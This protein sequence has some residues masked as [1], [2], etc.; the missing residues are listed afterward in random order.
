MSLFSIGLSGLSAAQNA[1]S[2]TSNNISNVYTDGYSRQ[3]TL[4]G[5]NS[6]GVG[7]GAGVSVD[8]IQRQY[9]SYI[10]SQLNQVNSRQSA[11]E[12]YQ[13]QINQIDDL[14]ADSD[15]GLTTLMQGFFSSVEDLTGAPADAAAREGLLGSSNSMAAQFRAYDGYLSD[16][17]E[18]IN[19]QI[20]DV[21]TQVNNLSDQISNL[22]KQV[23][24]ARARSGE[25]PNAL[26]DQRDKLVSDLGELV[27]V[28]VQVQD[29]STYQVS[30]S[31]GMPLV[32]GNQ[33][34]DLVAVKSSDDPS[35]TTIAYQDGA[36]SRSPLKESV[37]QGGEL[38]GLMSFR[39]ETLDSAQNQLGQLAVTLAGSFNKQHE[40]GLDLNGDPGEAFFDI[41]SPTVISRSTNTGSGSMSAEYGDVSELTADDYRLT[42]QADGSY[43]VENLGSGEISTISP[44]GDGNLSVAGVTLTP[45][46]SP[47]EGDVFM[48]QPTRHAAAG[49]DVALSDTSEIAAAAA[50]GGGSGD[51]R[52]A[53]ALLDLQN[54]KLVGGSATFSGG[55]ASLVSDV[56]NRTAITQANLTTQEGLSDQLYAY[57]QAD[58]GVNLD[59]EYANLLQFQQYF[60]AN[61]KVIEAGSTIMDTILGLRS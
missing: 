16:M 32:A 14:L 61:A 59:E 12:T 57:Q 43:S 49:F 58:S 30:L 4:L 42:Y 45:G 60:S 34:F 7:A 20:G 25:E 51:N 5:Q 52:N 54:Q 1:L 6:S 17:R 36:G 3:L 18:G 38:G 28:N 46:G 9:N 40:A 29:G 8:G 23:T 31:N 13:S 2:T 47:A 26:L 50:D 48:L 37:I 19:G 21:V 53:L 56:G 10:S 39:S 35:S 27:D 55:Y 15:S 11:L 22:N 24:L 33:S 41:G 44:D